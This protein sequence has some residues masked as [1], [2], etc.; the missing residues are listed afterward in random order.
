VTEEG[1]EDLTQCTDSFCKNVNL[2]PP[3]Y[4]VSKYRTG[5]FSN[6]SD[7]VDVSHSWAAR[8]QRTLHQPKFTEWY[9]DDVFPCIGY[10]N[11]YA[12]MK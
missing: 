8:S 6:K 9:G 10:V 1:H 4:E 5:K 11:I 12:I 2:G 3:E 7:D